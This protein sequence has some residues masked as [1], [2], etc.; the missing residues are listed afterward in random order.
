MADNGKFLC[1]NPFPNA[2]Y[3]T[4]ENTRRS[5]W[6]YL[7]L[8]TRLSFYI[9]NFFVFC[10]SGY[11]AKHTEF[12]AETQTVYSLKNLRITESCGGKVHL[13]GLD[14]IDKINGPAVIIANHMSLLETA[15]I[16][17]FLRPRKDFCFVIKQSL[18]DVPFFGN[19]MRKLGCIAVTRQN[20]RDDF[21]VVMSEGAKRLAEGKT[22]IIFP[23]HSRSAVFQEETFNT[24][25]VK[26]AKHAG[27]PILPLALRTDF[28]QNGKLLKDLGPIRRKRPIWFE[29]G[30]PI[31]EVKGTGKDEH[32]AVVNFIASR[33][34]EWGC[35]VE[36]QSDAK[37]EEKA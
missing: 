31:M 3:D 18:L 26:L 20:P 21:K 28:L 9:R 23:Q 2:T 37:A 15:V 13:R 35:E 30:E 7:L 16:H 24:I 22:V 32:K 27:V 8:G 29:F 25:G 19:I 4:P 6:E 17:A 11:L 33:L 10:R 34:K 12:T 1:D 5:I 36:M 14:N